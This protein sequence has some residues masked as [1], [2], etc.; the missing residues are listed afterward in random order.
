MNGGQKGRYPRWLRSCGWGLCPAFRDLSVVLSEDG[1]QLETYRLSEAK[2][3]HCLGCFGCW[4]KTPGMCV[5][6]DAGRQIARAVV[7]SDVTV[8]YTPVTFGGY[9]PALKKMVDR[10][11]Q[12][13]SPFFQ[14]EHGEVHHPPRYARRPRMIIVGVQR[15]ASAHEARIFKILAGRNA[16]NFH[17]S[18]YAAE[19]VVASEPAERLRRQFEALLT[20]SD[21]LPYGKSAAALMPPPVSPDAGGGPNGIQ[22]ALLIVGSPKMV[23]ASTSSILG[24]YLLK[25]LSQRGWETE[26]LVLRANLGREDGATALLESVARAGLIM[27]AF[28]LYVDALPHLATE[29]LALIAARRRAVAQPARQRLVAIVNSGFPET[30]QNSVAMAICCEFAAQSGMAWNGG[31]ALGGG[32]MIGGQPLTASRASGPP[33]KHVIRALDLAGEALSEGHPVPAEAVR[34]MAKNPIPLVP[35]ALWRRLYMH[36]GSKGFVQEAARNGVGEEGLL[37]QPYAASSVIA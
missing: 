35:F 7:Q 1:A 18:S 17:P 19:V 12:I 33:V 29:A 6:N 25:V 27:L 4:L 15:N 21:A 37:A 20:R 22:R 2:L 23:S 14:I 16:I 32:G 26:S 24:T 11:V 30:H 9:S 34:W 13:A 36:S 28:P 5:E 31:L 3:A 10:F 8:L